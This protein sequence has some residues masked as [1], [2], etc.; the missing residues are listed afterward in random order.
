MDHNATEIGDKDSKSLSCDT[1]TW[2]M[3]K[4]KFSPMQHNILSHSLS[5]VCCI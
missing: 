5:H 1:M 2:I 3:I 4:N